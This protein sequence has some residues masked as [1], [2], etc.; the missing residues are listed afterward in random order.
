M[1][2]SVVESNPNTSK[3]SHFKRFDE[4]NEEEDDGLA[5]RVKV[6]WS[7]AT[8]T[9]KLVVP[10]TGQPTWHII[11]GRFDRVSFR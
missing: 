8:T 6:K 9:S 10:Q 5:T 1:E 3:E 11:Y 2:V 7:Y 4:E